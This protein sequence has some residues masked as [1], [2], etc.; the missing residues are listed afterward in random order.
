MRRALLAAVTALGA[1]LVCELLLLVS[2]RASGRVAAVL[3][4]ASRALPD[5]HL[6]ERPNPALPDHDAAGWRNA[7]RPHHAFAVAIGDSQTYGEEVA[8][9]EAWP[10]R[11]AAL[12]GLSVY[13]LALGGYGP[14]EYERLLPEA[15][16]LSP[17][18]V[19]VGLYAGNDFADA[20]LDAYP[21]A[22]AAEL[23][24]RDEALL[25]HIAE[26]ERGGELKEAWERTRAARKGSRYGVLARRLEPVAE[27]SRLVALARAAARAVSG[28][29]G[30][31]DASGAGGFEALRA[32]AAEAGPDLLL[33]FGEAQ[34]STVFTPAARLA[35]LDTSDA[36]VEEGLHIALDRILQMSE[37]CAQR[38]RVAV[39][40]I[41]TKE[42][43]FAAHVHASGVPVPRVFAELALRENVVWER[44]RRALSA[45]GVPM[46]D[47]LPYLRGLLAEGTNPYRRDWNGHPDAAG[48]EAIARA[49]LDSGVLDLASRPARSEAKPNGDRTEGPRG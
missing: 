43:V 45:A 5:P 22:R 6:G 49:V 2:E 19:L 30:S 7:E 32:R 10:Q 20:Y 16:E 26:L 3:H 14:V 35:V 18:V 33:P 11:L 12:A 13:N 37:A 46:V 4:G 1:L 21:R 15:L 8:R 44:V 31:R 17:R 42:L 47:T 24:S 29:N 48:N 27:R 9:H 40:A 34:L 39:V 36:R 38:C 25:A 28:S 41:P 23:R